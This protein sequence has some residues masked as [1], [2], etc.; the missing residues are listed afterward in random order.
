MTGIHVHFMLCISENE[1]LTS[2]SDYNTFTES[3]YM[4]TCLCVHNLN[5]VIFT[6]DLSIQQHT[7]LH[8]NNY[9][10]YMI[11]YNNINR[12]CNS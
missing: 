5:K 10:V 2:Q 9:H 6:C 3:V 11:G 1:V 7:Y 8:Y 4:F 12:A